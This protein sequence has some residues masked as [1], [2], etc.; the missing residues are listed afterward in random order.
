[1]TPHL[2]FYQLIYTAGEFASYQAAGFS[3]IAA[4]KHFSSD[5][6]RMTR[7]ARDW[8]MGRRRRINIRQEGNRSV[9]IH[10]TCAHG[11]DDNSLLQSTK[12]RENCSY[13]RKNRNPAVGAGF[14]ERNIKRINGKW[15]SFLCH[16][17]DYLKHLHE[18]ICKTFCGVATWSYTE[19]HKDNDFI[20]WIL[21]YF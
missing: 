4:R 1:M 17:N 6:R 2:M 8:L 18:T 13:R 16:S 3:E 14:K 20:H 9:R 5:L 21:S 15:T 11:T 10:G 7:K 19:R 12:L